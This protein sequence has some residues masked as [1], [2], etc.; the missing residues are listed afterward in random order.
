M[1]IRRMR[2]ARC[3]RKTTKHTHTLSLSLS[4]SLSQNVKYIA[5]PLQQWLREPA[6]CYVICTYVHVLFK[7]LQT[8]LNLWY[9][10]RF[11]SYRSVNTQ[12]LGY[13]NQ[14]VNVVL[15]SNLCSE[16]HTKDIKAN[17]EQNVEFPNVHVVGGK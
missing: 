11:S 7:L 17:R 14:E 16:N 8:K 13:K 9:S 1:T 5:F 2:V 4:L 10:L 15:G 12:H 3:V 6:L